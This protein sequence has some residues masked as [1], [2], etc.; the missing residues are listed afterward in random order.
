MPWLDD[1]GLFLRSLRVPSQWLD[2][3]LRDPGSFSG[4][5]VNSFLVNRV[6]AALGRAYLARID[7]ALLCSSAVAAQHPAIV[8]ST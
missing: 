4:S 1:P 6:H 2:W 3:L 5:F 8:P 7:R